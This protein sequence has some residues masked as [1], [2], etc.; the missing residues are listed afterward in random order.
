MD[1]A[2][3]RPREVARALGAELSTVAWSGKGVTNNYGDDVTD[4]M[5]KIYDR[6]LAAD[7][8]PWSFVWQPDAVVINLG[9][10]DFSTDGDP[11]EGVFVPAYV[12]F[13]AHLRE[14]YPQAFVLVVAPSLWGDEAAM[15]AGYLQ[16]VVDQRHA[17]GD[18]EVAFADV[19]V[20][21]IGSGCDGHPSLATHAGM[22]DKLT[23]A[24]QAELGW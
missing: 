18:L 6:L 19:N 2:T 4:P 20:E 17:A 10:N 16:S 15:V 13:L 24:L 8:D 12:E 5:P 23:A 7:D 9:T 22:A 1:P 3:P 14:V 21:W 11:A